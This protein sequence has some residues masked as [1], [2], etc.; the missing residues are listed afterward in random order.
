[1]TPTVATPAS[2]TAK[3]KLWLFNIQIHW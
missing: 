3:L 2:K 1:M